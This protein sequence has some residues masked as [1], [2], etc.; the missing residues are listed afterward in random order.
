MNYYHF[1]V[2][3]CDNVVR[4]KNAYDGLNRLTSAVYGEGPGLADKANRYDE[5]VLAYSANG[6]V[7]LS[8]R[9][10]STSQTTPATAWSTHTTAREP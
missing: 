7:E 9:A 4:T 3:H 6:A 8:T 2:P 1:C 5:E 10:R